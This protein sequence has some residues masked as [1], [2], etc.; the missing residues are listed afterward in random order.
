MGGTPAPKGEPSP[1]L[2]PKPILAGLGA[3]SEEP[4]MLLQRP[5]HHQDPHLPKSV[6][7][8]EVFVSMV[9]VG[10]GAIIH[11]LRCMHSTAL[12][13]LG[14][15]LVDPAGET[16]EVVT[17]KG[18]DHI[19][20]HRAEAGRTYRLGSPFGDS[21]PGR[22]QPLRLTPLSFTHRCLTSVSLFSLTCGS[23]G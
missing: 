16:T 6:I 2:D 13:P 11:V 15:R 1:Y 7:Y 21:N 5:N 4:H 20:R 23:R 9:L 17:A 3:P 22:R 18:L 12:C 14:A 19:G 10:V 8:T